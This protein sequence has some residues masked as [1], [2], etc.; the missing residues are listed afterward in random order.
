MAT[1]KQQLSYLKLK[2]HKNRGRIDTLLPAFPLLLL[3][4]SLLFMDAQM[5]PAY[6]PIMLTDESRQ[7]T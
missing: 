7:G 6:R 5:V 4:S 1:R 3:S 2:I